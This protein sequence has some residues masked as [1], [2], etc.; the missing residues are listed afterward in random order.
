MESG[1]FDNREVLYLQHEHRSQYIWNAPVSSRRVVRTRL[2]ESAWDMLEAIRPHPRVIDILRRGGIYRCIEALYRV[3]P[4]EMLPYHQE[5][6]RLTGYEPLQRDMHVRSRLLRSS[7]HAHLR[8]VDLQ[9]PID[10]ATPQADVDRRARLYLL[11]IFGGIMFPN[12][13]GADMSIRYLL[14]IEDL[15]QL[16]CYSWGAAVLACMYR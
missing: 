13:S 9:G 5:L 16:G 11:I 4:P 8:L 7:L 1:P 2:G 15:D 10:E 12:T 3:E 14:F 6:A